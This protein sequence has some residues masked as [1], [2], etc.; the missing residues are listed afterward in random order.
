[1][2]KSPIR[3]HPETSI[4]QTPVPLH[5][6]VQGSGVHVLGTVQAPFAVHEDL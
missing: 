5:G 3:S 1:M 6:S 2:V 4:E